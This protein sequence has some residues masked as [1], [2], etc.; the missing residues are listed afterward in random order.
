M[1]CPQ[2]PSPC[3]LSSISISMFRME[4]I[5]RTFKV[6]IFPLQNKE[7]CAVSNLGQPCV[8]KVI[9]KVPGDAH[10]AWSKALDAAA[11]LAPT[12]F[13]CKNDL[14]TD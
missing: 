14:V 9:A 4:K 13:S 3:S 5:Y 10:R 6:M 1:N 8:Q 7:H 12:D 11:A 2:P